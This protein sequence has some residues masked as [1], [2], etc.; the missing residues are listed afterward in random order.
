MNWWHDMAVLMCGLVCSWF[1]F[2]PLSSLFFSPFPFRTT[3]QPLTFPF[4]TPHTSGGAAATQRH[5][6]RACSTQGV[7]RR[8][9]QGAYPQQVDHPTSGGGGAT[10]FPAVFRF[11]RVPFH[12]LFLWFSWHTVVPFHVLCTIHSAPFMVL[13]KLSS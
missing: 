3:N 9:G 8:H 12:V 5:A 13:C 7:G 6:T 2:G 4:I 11:L 1:C 10:A